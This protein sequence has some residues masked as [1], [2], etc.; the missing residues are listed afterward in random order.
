M[1]NTVTGEKNYRMAY[2]K[3]GGRKNFRLIME[4]L[5]CRTEKPLEVSEKEKEIVQ[6]VFENWLTA[7]KP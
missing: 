3:S 5:E 6:A 1:Y 4:G 2:E 7:R